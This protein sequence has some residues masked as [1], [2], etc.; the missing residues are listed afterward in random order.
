MWQFVTVEASA[1]RPT[2]AIL[3]RA[4]ELKS[5]GLKHAGSVKH[6]LTHRRYHFDVYC[7]ESS[8]GKSLK[9]ERP[10]A[11]VRLCELDQYPLPRPH[12]KIAEMLR[13]D[14]AIGTD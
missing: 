11:W 9:S 2:P 4:I 1:K 13:K 3:R 12:L 10:R 8:D 5:T 14:V 6:A 7:C